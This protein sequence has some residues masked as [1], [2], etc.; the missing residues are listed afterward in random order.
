MFIVNTEHPVAIDSPDHIKPWGTKRD[1]HSS[2]EFINEAMEFLNLDRAPKFMDIGCSGGALVKDWL[3]HTKQ[4]IGIEGS[5]YSA[6]NMRAEWWNLHNKNLFTCDA[7]R[8][9]QITFDGEPFKAD[10]IT[11]WEVMEHLHPDR[12][13]TVFDNVYNHLE[14]GGCFMGTIHT[15]Q[16]SP[17]GLELH[18]ACFPKEKWYNEIVPTDK[19]E[20]LDYPLKSYVRTT[21]GFYFCFKKRA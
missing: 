17:E 14:V 5:D 19:F 18:I 2:Q 13:D 16:D 20:I 4:S 7:T 8:P 15:E 1:N 10:L 11:A 3:Q 12:L 6:R 9:Y 21:G